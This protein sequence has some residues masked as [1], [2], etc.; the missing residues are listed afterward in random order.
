MNISKVRDL[1]NRKSNN[2][3]S[4]IH[5]DAKAIEA[6]RFMMANRIGSLMVQDEQGEPIGIITERDILSN[7]SNELNGFA[8]RTVADVM[9]ADPIC[10]LPDDDIGYITTVMKNNN[11]RHLPIVSNNK[12]VGLISMRDILDGLLE[13]KNVENRK[14]HEYLHLSGRL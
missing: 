4:F 6:A 7:I 5:P 10:G 9:T 1:L 8:D 12:V 13:A 14:L 11:I 2:V 3:V